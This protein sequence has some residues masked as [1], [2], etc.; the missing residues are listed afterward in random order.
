MCLFSRRNP[1]LAE[2]GFETQK[3]IPSR[4]TCLFTKFGRNPLLAEDRFETWLRKRGWLHA[5]RAS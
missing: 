1:L 4:R 3:A 5:A 2:D